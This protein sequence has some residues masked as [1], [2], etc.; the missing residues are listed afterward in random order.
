M[1]TGGHS[2]TGAWPGATVETNMC[3]F[4]KLQRSRV[5]KLM[6]NDFHTTNAYDIAHVLKTINELFFSKSI[7]RSMQ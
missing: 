6:C 3:A 7:M 1:W 4:Y 5:K 2:R